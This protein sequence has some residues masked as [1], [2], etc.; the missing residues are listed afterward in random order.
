MNYRVTRAFRLPFRVFPY[1]E[2]VS[3]FRLELVIKLRA[4]IPKNTAVNVSLVVPMPLTTAAASC[5]N[6]KTRVGAFFVSSIGS[7]GAW[8]GELKRCLEGQKCLF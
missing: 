1:V 8:F 3:P 7:S 2:I 5:T 4:D 6:L